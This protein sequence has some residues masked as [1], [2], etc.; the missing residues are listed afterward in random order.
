MQLGSVMLVFNRYRTVSI[1]DA[2]IY[3]KITCLVNSVLLHYMVNANVLL[4]LRPVPLSVLDIFQLVILVWSAYS[5][6][7]VFS[8]LPYEVTTEQAL[9][10]PEVKRQIQECVK[11]LQSLTEMFLNRI[12]T[13]LNSIPS[14]LSSFG[15]FCF[16]FDQ[17][18]CCKKG[19]AKGKNL[20]VLLMQR[21][22][23]TVC[24]GQCW[25]C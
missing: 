22:F 13:S 17:I 18:L 6:V 3:W 20:C 15:W 10:H 24:Y 21:K 2:S 1:H 23:L 12:V 5:H 11:Q 7:P 25:K 16:G 9:Q 8:D 19:C 4:V 14:V